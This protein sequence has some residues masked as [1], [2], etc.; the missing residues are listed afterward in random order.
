MI[1][2]HEQGYVAINCEALAVAWAPQKNHH[3]LFGFHIIP[4]TDEKRPTENILSQG[5]AN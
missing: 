5:E 1:K 2:K 4:K 3:V